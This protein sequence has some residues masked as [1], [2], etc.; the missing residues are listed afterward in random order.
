MFDIETFI[1]STKADFIDSGQIVEDNFD[2]SLIDLE[3]A[4]EQNIDLTFTLIDDCADNATCVSSVIIIPDAKVYL[5][6]TISISDTGINNTFTVFGN[7][8]VAEVTKF[9]IYDRWGNLVWE[10]DPN[11]VINDE[12]F[13]FNATNL[14]NRTPGVYT[15]VVEILDVFEDSRSI[16]GHLTLIK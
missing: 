8:S 5:P 12:S 6:N 4:Q 11:F 9:M 16:T 10:K 3:C 13:G 7:T 2:S 15:Y 14:G 1:E